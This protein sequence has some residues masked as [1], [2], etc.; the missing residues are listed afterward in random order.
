MSKK[1]SDLPLV[2]EPI[3]RKRHDL[4]DLKRKRESS[5]QHQKVQ[6]KKKGGKKTFYVKKLETVISRARSRSNNNIR[7][8][9][10]LK[11]GMQTRASN[12]KIKA[13]KE[14]EEDGVVTQISYQANSVGS[15]MVFAIRI[16]DHTG[17]PSSVR[18]AMSRLR[19]RNKMDGVFLRYDDG[20]RKLLHLVEPWVIYGQPEKGVVS[21]LVTRR[22]YG[23]VDGKRVALSDNTVIQ[24]NLEEADMICVEDLVHALHTAGDNFRAASSFLWPFR[25][26]ESKTAFELQTLGLKDNKVYGDIGED[27][28]EKIKEIL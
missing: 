1:K 5:A 21:D 27:I 4:E 16:R 11:K 17:A 23:K 2:P 7:Y 15:K 13:T 19:L 6:A 22:G 3:L 25:L 8:N 9:R 20:T 10:V 12:K 28:N 14:I 18:K 26:A 24:D